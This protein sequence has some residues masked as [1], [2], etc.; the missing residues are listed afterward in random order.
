MSSGGGNEEFS[1]IIKK[2]KGT[3]EIVAEQKEIFD[4]I[5]VH[6]QQNTDC[7]IILDQN[8]YI[9]INHTE[10]IHQ[11]DSNQSRTVITSSSTF[12]RGNHT[13]KRSTW[14]IKLGCRYLSHL[15]EISTKIKTAT[16]SD[17]ISVNKVIKFIKN[18]P[19]HIKIPSFDLGSLEI[20]P[21]SDASFNNLPDGGSR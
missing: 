5:G 10:S 6:L 4:C 17:I 15:C 1:C 3:F 2:L 7:S 13:S 14:K 8:Q 20:H 19:S 18:T 21:Y 16:I 11:P 12:K 9:R